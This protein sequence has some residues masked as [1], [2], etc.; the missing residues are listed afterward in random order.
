LPF[1][2][3]VC[4]SVASSREFILQIARKSLICGGGAGGHFVVK[5][6]NHQN[7]VWLCNPLPGGFGH[8]PRSTRTG[9][10]GRAARTIELILPVQ[11]GRGT[12]QAAQRRR[13]VEGGICDD[14]DEHVDDCVTSSL[15]PL[16]SYFVIADALRRRSFN[17][18][19]PMAYV[20]S[21]RAQGGK[22][23]AH[24][25]NPFRLPSERIRPN[26]CLD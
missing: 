21:P 4:W 11:R 19:R 22:Q 24:C 5:L 8:Q 25:L 13:M 7:F 14:A 2:A 12:I 3:N 26:G 6:L 15:A 17:S 18:R 16:P 10:R 20:P 23:R 9:A 1:S